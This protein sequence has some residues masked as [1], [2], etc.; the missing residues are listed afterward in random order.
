M[1][2]LDTDHLS[3]LVDH[4]HT[5]GRALEQRLADSSE[6]VA[7]TIVSVEEQLRG[8]LAQIRRVQDA[9]KQIVPYLRLSKLIDFLRDWNVVEWNEPAAEEFTSVRKQ[10]IRIGTQ[11]LKIAAIAKVNDA[12][13]LSANLVDFQRVPGLRVEDWLHGK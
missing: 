2:V 10:R 1:I 9:H 3:A 12:L 6:V 4:R 7:V 11:D 13:L 8:W 5:L